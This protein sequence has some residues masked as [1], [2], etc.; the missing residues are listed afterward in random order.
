MSVYFNSFKN[1]SPMEKN[2]AVKRI[3][4]EDEFSSFRKLLTRSIS[5]IK[6][7]Q[8]SERSNGTEITTPNSTNVQI[9]SFVLIK[10]FLSF[11]QLISVRQCSGP[12]KAYENKNNSNGI[13]YANIKEITIKNM[14]NLSMFLLS[15]VFQTTNLIKMNMRPK[16]FNTPRLK[17]S[18]IAS[19]GIC[20]WAL[21]FGYSTFE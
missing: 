21:K 14:F 12:R 16:K 13:L 8:G 6:L 3:T 17:S 11:S 2:S 4:L 9:Q 15:I 5:Q 1:T 10:Q 20:D 19:T 7:N 18:L